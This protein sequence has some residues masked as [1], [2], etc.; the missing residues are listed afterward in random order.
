MEYCM[1]HG[2]LWVSWYVFVYGRGV[3]PQTRVSCIMVRCFHLKRPSYQQGWVNPA[4]ARNLAF[5]LVSVDRYTKGG[6]KGPAADFPSRCLVKVLPLSKHFLCPRPIFHFVYCSGGGEEMGVGGVAY[7]RL[8]SPLYV[9]LYNKHVNFFS[10][11]MDIK[12]CLRIN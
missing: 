10:K 4:R 2:A 6:A 5:I 3:S 11:F 7:L 9:S 8:L 12:S 1:V